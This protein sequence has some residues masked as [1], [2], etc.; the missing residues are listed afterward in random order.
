MKM[1]DVSCFQIN[2]DHRRDRW[3][4][5]VKNRI[6]LGY[7][8]ESFRKFSAIPEEFGGLG[9]AESHLLALTELYTR[10]KSNYLMILED[11][12]RFSVAQDELEHRVSEFE[13]MVPGWDVILLNGT[14]VR[15]KAGGYKT[16]RPV[17]EC[18]ST[19]GY[20][21]RK[22]YA[23]RVMGIFLKSVEYLKMYHNAPKGEVRS[24]LHS[25]FAIDVMWKQ[26]QWK[27]RWFIGD[28]SFGCTESGYSDIEGAY[29]DQASITFV[30]T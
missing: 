13:E 19:A 21:V 28:P 4:A 26:L 12:F 1:K 11:D 22:E 10:S 25:K 30:K 27:D 14:L 29:M 20:I 24:Y 5:G 15:L 6:D 17:F 8:Q 2:L 23:P 3:N 9:C 16:L 7:S 18:H